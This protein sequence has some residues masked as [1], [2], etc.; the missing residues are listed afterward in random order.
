LRIV[1]KARFWIIEVA[2]EVIGGDGV[3]LNLVRR[4]FP[5]QRLGEGGGP[6]A[7]GGW[8]GKARFRP[9]FTRGGDKN[10][11][12]LPSRL[13]CGKQLLRQLEWRQQQRLEGRAQLVREDVF[14]TR[15]VLG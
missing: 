10:K 15:G 5:G 13:H 14:D 7:N 9:E 8:N 11:R 6:G 2:R 1:F 4:G 3:H 12:S